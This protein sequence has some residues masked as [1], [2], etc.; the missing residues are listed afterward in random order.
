MGC[1]SLSDGCSRDTSSDC[2]SPGSSPSTR[3]T[4]TAPPVVGRSASATF[5]PVLLLLPVSSGSLEGHLKQA[6][7]ALSQLPPSR[8]PPTGQASSSAVQPGLRGR[9]FCSL[10]HAGWLV[11]L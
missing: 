7:K 1:F 9:R 11:V 4:P 3:A 6:W 10:P 2:S 5:A 8:S